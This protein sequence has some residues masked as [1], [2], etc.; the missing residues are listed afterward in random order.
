MI[1]L[2]ERILNKNRVRVKKFQCL[3]SFK[4]Q[5]Y[6]GII[7]IKREI[8]VVEKEVFIQHGS[9]IPQNFPST[10]LIIPPSLG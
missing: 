9:I 5:K 1:I 4:W 2:L 3:L 8:D 10:L 6:L 7:V